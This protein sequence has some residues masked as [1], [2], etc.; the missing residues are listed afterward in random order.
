[1]R[2]LTT[3][4]FILPF[5]SSA[6]S[7]DVVVD[8]TTTEISGGVYNIVTSSAQED[9]TVRIE[10]H[11]GTDQNWKFERVL[12]STSYWNDPTLSWY[13][14]VNVL[15]GADF[16]VFSTQSWITPTTMNIADSGE[17]V[18]ILR[19][20][21]VEVGCDLYQYYILHNDVRVDSF[22]INLCKTVGLNEITPQ[23]LSIYPN[24]S[25]YSLNLSFQTQTPKEVIIYDLLGN[26]IATFEAMESMSVSTQNF[27]NG[28]YILSWK[29]EEMTFRQKFQVH[30]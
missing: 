21:A 2:S 30:H 7:I 10:N 26:K 18:V 1:M 13:D 4:L 3:L 23:N 12:P 16:V 20:E 6:Q 5:L 24:P 14:P 8:N 28:S 15:L 17:M 22:R 27:L 9:L 25:N 11:T 19:W 29:L